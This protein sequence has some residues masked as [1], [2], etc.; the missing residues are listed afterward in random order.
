MF[1]ETR[2]VAGEGSRKRKEESPAV[3]DLVGE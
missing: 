3:E 1:G 2:E